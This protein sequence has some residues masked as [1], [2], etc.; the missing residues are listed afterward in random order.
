V[1]TGSCVADY[2]LQRTAQADLDKNLTYQ[3]V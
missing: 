2:I 3:I 1:Y